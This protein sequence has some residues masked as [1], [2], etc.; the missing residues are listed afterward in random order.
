MFKWIKSIKEKIFPVPVP[1]LTE[2]DIALLTLFKE[3]LDFIQANVLD[4][5]NYSYHFYNYGGTNCRCEVAV[6]GIGKE[7]KTI[8]LEDAMY[9]TPKA[10]EVTIDFAKTQLDFD[11]RYKECTDIFSQWKTL[12]KNIEILKDKEKEEARKKRIEN[13]LTNIRKVTAK[14]I[15]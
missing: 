5:Q 6:F 12:C 15:K 13:S 9:S 8:E 7:N 11:P 3:T 2:E 1:S 10:L 4:K 14:K